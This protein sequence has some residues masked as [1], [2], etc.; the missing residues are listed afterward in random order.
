MPFTVNAR[1]VSGIHSLT[2]NF[3]PHVALLEV[4]TPSLYL[5][6]TLTL[7]ELASM[8]ETC[9][10]FIPEMALCQSLATSFSRE[11]YEAVL[12]DVRDGHAASPE[13]W[14]RYRKSM[15]FN[16]KKKMGACRD[17]R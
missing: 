6:S 17:G 1:I 9:E 16:D 10:D 7:D 12:R 3:R 5:H 2:C 8:R 15:K 14:E 11:L 4:K 13:T